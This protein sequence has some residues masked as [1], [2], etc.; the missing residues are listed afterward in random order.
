MVGKELL[1]IRNNEIE[2]EAEYFQSKG[3]PKSPVVLICHP[4]PQYGGNMHNNVVSGVY[5]KLIKNDI[6]CLRFN[7]RGVGKSTGNHSD[8]IGELNDVKVCVDFLIDEKNHERII[9]CGYSYGAAIGCSAINHTDNIIGYIAISFPFDFVGPKYRALSQS[10]KPKLFIQGD[11]DTIA[12]YERFQ[13]NYNFYNVPKKK[14]II[15]GADHFYWNYEE[16]V[17]EKVFEFYNDFD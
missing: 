2:L 16:Q 4:H 3:N 5:N 10:N 8:G 11:Q 9:I 12:S 15:N 14:E 1:F 6:P 13:N 7:F 17:A